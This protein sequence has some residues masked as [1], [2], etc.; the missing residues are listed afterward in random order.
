MTHKL[1]MNNLHIKG[2]IT[3]SVTY[4]TLERK[5]KL[6]DIKHDRIYRM[7]KYIKI[8]LAYFDYIDEFIPCEKCGKKSIDIHHIYGRGKGKD[9]IYNLM[10]LCRECHTEAHSFISKKDIQKI[11]NSFIKNI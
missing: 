9:T 3:D 10:A 11:H 1:L 2:R 6:S 7:Q 4:I 5:I 8:Y